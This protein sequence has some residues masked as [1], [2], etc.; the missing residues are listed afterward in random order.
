M[1]ASSTMVIKVKYGDMLRRFNAEIVE[2]DL[3][4]SMDGLRKKI[5]SLF[6]LAPDTE[7]MLTYI[8]EDGDVV[9][10]VDDDDLHD[11][12][13]QA[14]NP[15]RITIKV[16]AEK[17]GRRTVPEP[18]RETL[19]KLSADLASKASSSA[20]AITELVDYLSKVSLS[21]LGQLSEDQPRAKSSMQDDVPESSTAA[22]ETN[23]LFKVDPGTI[24]KVYPM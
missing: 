19:V 2:E 20:P 21:Y 10:L 18:L 17:N 11:V 24:L 8:D 5:R 6:S 4:L 23:E 14:L 7:L 15:L 22:R 3:N 16:N 9:T 1:E 12:V 13:K